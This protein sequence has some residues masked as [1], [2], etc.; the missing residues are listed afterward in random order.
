[1]ESSGSHRRL[2]LMMVRR[3]G[4]ASPSRLEVE[5]FYRRAEYD[6]TADVPS[7]AG[8]SG[9]K[10]TEEIPTATDRIGSVTSHNLFA[11]LYFDFQTSSR[12]TPYVGVGVGVGFTDM[13]YGCVWARNPDP[14]AIAT[15]AGL[16]NAAEIRWNLAGTTSVA[17]TELRDRLFGY[18]VLFGVDYALTESVS[19]GV[20]GRWVNFDS[21][22]TGSSGTRFAVTGPICAATAVNRCRAGSRPTIS[23]CSG[24]A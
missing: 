7:G 23:K 15:G 10:L 22:V 4:G 21:S 2:A 17:Q 9:D 12:F 1:M 24:S 6:E 16:P 20:K 11:N 18:Q 14:T 3:F 13:D 19:L 5:Y 8:E